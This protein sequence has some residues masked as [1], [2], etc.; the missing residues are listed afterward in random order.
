[1]GGFEFRVTEEIPG[2]KPGVP[3][4]TKVTLA[5]IKGDRELWAREL[6]GNPWSPPPP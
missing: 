1:M 4:V 2:I 3:M 6:A 5:L